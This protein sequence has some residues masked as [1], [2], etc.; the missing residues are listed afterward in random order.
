MGKV[1]VVL[2]SLCICEQFFNVCIL[3]WDL[4]PTYHMDVATFLIKTLLMLWHGF[5]KKKSY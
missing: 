2:N 4:I 3:I 1:N 5:V